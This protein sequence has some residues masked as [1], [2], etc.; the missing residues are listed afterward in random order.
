MNVTAPTEGISRK[1]I[2]YQ[3]LINLSKNFVKINSNSETC[4][5][6]FKT[7]KAV[8]IAC[9]TLTER[10]LSIRISVKIK[11]NLTTIIPKTQV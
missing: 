3:F 2:N 9:I 11:Q 10:L 4:Q 5:T 8:Q 1:Q 6:C 7:S